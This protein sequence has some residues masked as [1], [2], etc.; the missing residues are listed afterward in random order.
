[1]KIFI[2]TNNKKGFTLLELL[3]SIS[4]ISILLLAFLTIIL[5]SIKVNTKNDKDI[6]ALHIAQ[7]EIEVVRKQ[8]KDG[9]TSFVNSEN[10]GLVINNTLGNLYYKEIDGKR[11]EVRFYLDKSLESNLYNLRVIVK[12]K[13]MDTEDD[14]FSKKTTELVTQVYGI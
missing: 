5:S 8:I 7:S 3:V 12:S 14:Y 13:S 6:S 2:K 10:K 9:N 4:I 11:F 1:M